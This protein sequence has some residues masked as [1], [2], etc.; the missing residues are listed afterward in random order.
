MLRGHQYQNECSSY[1]SCI[2][3][4]ALECRKQLLILLEENNY[5]KVERPWPG[6]FSTLK[7]EDQFY[8]CYTRNIHFGTDAP[9]AWT[10]LFYNYH[11]R[12]SH[13]SSRISVNSCPI[14]AAS[15]VLT[16]P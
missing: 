9:E 1:S 4:P 15:G 2:V 12:K 14:H 11:E 5:V 3:N 6:L 8:C 7:L 10:G 16:N 13:E